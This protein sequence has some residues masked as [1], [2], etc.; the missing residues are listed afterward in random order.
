[1]T[2]LD[3]SLMQLFLKGGF[4]MRPLLLCSILGAAIVLE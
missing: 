4:A 2:I 1:M 3:Q